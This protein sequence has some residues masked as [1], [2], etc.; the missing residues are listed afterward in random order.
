MSP[1]LNMNQIAW[2]PVFDRTGS[3]GSR[4]GARDMRPLVQIIS[5]SCSFRQKFDKLIGFQTLLRSWRPLENPGSAT[6]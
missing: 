4:G 6:H 1:A 3:D 5:F 2:N